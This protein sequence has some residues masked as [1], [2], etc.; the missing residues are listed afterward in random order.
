[1]RGIKNAG[2]NKEIRKSGKFFPRR[3]LIPVTSAGGFERECLLDLHLPMKSL[4]PALLLAV[5]A[6]VLA[7]TDFQTFQAADVV[8]GQPDFT[9]TTPTSGQPNRFNTSYCAAMDPT[10]GKVFVADYGNN[11]V[12]RFSS[13]AAAQ[14]GSNPEA[15]FGQ[16]NFSASSANQGGAVSASTLSAPVGVSVDSS[17]RLWVAD[18]F[19]NRVLGFFL[20][21]FLSNDPP[22]DV[23]I[24]Q[25]NF[26]SNAGATTQTG[27]NSPAFAIV[28][29]DDTLWSP[30]MA[31]IA[32]CATPPFPRSR[33]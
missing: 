20:A 6:P 8:L 1:M 33:R 13:A 23:V 27:L 25:A 19:N 9:T 5:A 12:L 22:A 3:G 2:R 30:T 7:A 31:T 32:S 18:F 24:G 26:T 17:G 29:P 15:V 10:T 16:M 21:S 11:R 4:L 28:G 14:N